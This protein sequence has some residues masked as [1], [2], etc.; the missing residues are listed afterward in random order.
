MNHQSD[1]AASTRFANAARLRWQ[2]LAEELR[3]DV[4]EFNSHRGAADFVQPSVNQFHVSNSRTGL[5]LSI[6]ADFEERIIRY[7]YEQVNNKSAGAPEGGI[8]SMRES[9]PGVVEFYSADEQLTREE[10]RDVLLEPVLFP[11]EMAA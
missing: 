1:N 8:L 5:L 6:T 11:P 9:S 3:G 10:T 2:E 4:A 7:A